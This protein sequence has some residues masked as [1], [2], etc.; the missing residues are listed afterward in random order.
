[1]SRIFLYVLLFALFISG[2]LVSSK[3]KDDLNQNNQ[4]ITLNSDSSE[5]DGKT[6]IFKHCGNAILTQPGISLV[7]DCLIGKKSKNG[8]Y[9]FIAAQGK[10]ARLIQT[11]LVKNDTLKVS[12]NLIE[13]K[14]PKQQFNIIENA[15]LKILSNDIDSIEIKANRI[16]LDNK[17]PDN[18]DITATGK[19]LK[20]ELIKL[21]KTDLKAEAEKLHFNTRSSEL[22]LS[23]DVVA[24]LE[25][26][27]ISAGVFK[28]NSETKISS[29]KKSEDQQVEIIQKKK[30]S[31]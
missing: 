2:Q 27:Q 13:Y 5:L 22:E 29:F 31:K 26:G 3:E 8:S 12:A 20:I 14:V 23:D 21:G 24:H 1:M 4:N 25:L 18:R 6:G 10:P 7:A 11:S 30:E 28:Y 9:E 19:P 15:E 17:I 16:Q